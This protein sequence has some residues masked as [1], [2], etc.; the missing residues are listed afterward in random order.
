MTSFKFITI[1]AVIV[2]VVG[3]LVDASECKSRE[4]VELLSVVDIIWIVMCASLAAA[5]MC[6]AKKG[7]HSKENRAL[8]LDFEQNN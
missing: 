3:G 8:T 7:T 1:F 2:V 4:E 5:D 6:C